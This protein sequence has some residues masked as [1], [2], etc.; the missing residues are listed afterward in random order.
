M[1]PYE[2]DGDDADLVR[3]ETDDADAIPK[4]IVT[5]TG[6]DW[7]GDRPPATPWNETLIYEV[8]VKGFSKRHPGV[9]EDLRGTYAGLASDEAVAH[10]RSLG[11]RR[12]S[13]CRCTT[14][15]TRCTWS[16]WGSP[17]TGGTAP[18]GSSRPTRCT[19]PRGATGSRSTSSRG[20]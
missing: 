2:P 19:P 12:W 15:P 18:S 6:F 4:G 1:L 11:S 16:T 17:T 10:L 13:C 20:W 5:D 8:H 7:E 3:D 14:T 9:R